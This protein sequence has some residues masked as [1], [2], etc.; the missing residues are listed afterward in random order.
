MKEFLNF[1]NFRIN[2][3]FLQHSIML[4]VI[5]CFVFSYKCLYETYAKVMFKNTYIELIDTPSYSTTKQI[6]EDFNSLE[7]NKIISFKKI[8]YGRP[9][10]IVEMSSFLE[11]LYPDALGI[12][13]PQADK[14]TITIKKNQF[15]MDYKETLLHEYLHC[16]G[17]DHSPN[18]YDIMY[19]YLIPVD[20]EENIKY[21]AKKLRNKYYE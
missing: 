8:K 17:F 18:K 16:M 9:V 11:E 7:D 21:Y 10:K 12:T 15:W 2:T 14:C 3:I 4:Y 1:R 20:K 13:F 19:K 6:L 5:L